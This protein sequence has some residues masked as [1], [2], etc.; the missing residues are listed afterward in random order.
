MLRYNIA[1]P[2]AEKDVFPHLTGDKN[3]DPGI[4]VFNA[5]H[6]GPKFFDK[7]PAGYPADLYV[8]TVPDC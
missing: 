6:A 1:H 4:V 8:P 2:G 7:P 5:G 3:H